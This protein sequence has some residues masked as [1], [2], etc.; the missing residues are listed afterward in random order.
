MELYNI[1]NLRSNRK[2]IEGGA[3]I[4]TISSRN[5]WFIAVV[6]GVLGGIKL[7]ICEMI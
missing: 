4:A 7:Y 3:A 6:N 2:T 1:Y 5:I